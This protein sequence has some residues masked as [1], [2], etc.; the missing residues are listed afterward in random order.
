MERARLTHIA[1]VHVAGQEGHRRR[2]AAALA[3]GDLHRLARDVLEAVLERAPVLQVHDLAQPLPHPTAALSPGAV[4]EGLAEGLQVVET[5]GEQ[6]WQRR[7]D[8]EVVDV[9]AQLLVEPGCLVGVEKCTV[10]GV[11]LSGRTRVDDDQPGLGV[12]L[13]RVA[14]PVGLRL[15]VDPLGEGVDDGTEVVLLVAA[16]RQHLGI[17]LVVT[18]LGRGHVAEVLVDPVGPEPGDDAAVPP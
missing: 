10:V 2:G 3:S 17:E 4:G 6:E 15:L 1:V 13:A 18:A 9:A 12:E 14:P 16:V 7:P 11:E 8:E 5:T